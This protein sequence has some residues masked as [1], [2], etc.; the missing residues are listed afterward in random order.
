MGLAG[1][2]SRVYCSLAAAFCFHCLLHCFLSDSAVPGNI[3]IIAIVLCLG[4][5]MARASLLCPCCWAGEAGDPVWSQDED[6]VTCR[7]VHRGAGHPKGSV[8]MDQFTAE[9]VHLKASVAMVVSVVRQV[10]PEA[11][12]AV[13]EVGKE[14]L[15]VCG[16]VLQVPHMIVVLKD[17]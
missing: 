5:Q 6:I 3:L 15:E 4:W 13:H 12:V 14:N 1:L 10:H 7:W 8:A 9:Q 17:Q 11:S 2:C 16:H